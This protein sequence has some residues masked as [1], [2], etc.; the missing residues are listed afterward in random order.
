M[1]KPDITLEPSKGVVSQMAA[2]IYSA[3]ITR[4]VVEQ[5]EEA[6]WMERSI[7]EAV[8]IARTVDVSTES[9][10]GPSPHQE[11]TGGGSRASAPASSASPAP[12][13]PTSPAAENADQA[14]RDVELD[15]VI[16][17]ASSG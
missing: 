2:Q 4:G 13:P 7:R 1:T 5:G 16:G 17:K 11:S 10:E 9:D 6:N 12:S 8:R 15:D 3:Y 14:L